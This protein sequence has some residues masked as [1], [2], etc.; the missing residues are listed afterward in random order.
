MALLYHAQTDV[1]RLLPDTEFVD[2]A[3]GPPVVVASDISATELNT[4]MEQTEAS[5]R[6]AL[7]VYYYMNITGDNALGSYS[8]EVINE[9]CTFISAQKCLDILKI[10]PVEQPIENEK[11]RSLTFGEKGWRIINGIVLYA[12][13]GYVKGA[14][15]LEDA[16]ANTGKRPSIGFNNDKVPVNKKGTERY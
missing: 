3:D 1:E 6:A 15:I 9:A 5:I 4:L 16:T 8:Q 13:K 11:T 2:A 14:V 7:A 10:N 12:T